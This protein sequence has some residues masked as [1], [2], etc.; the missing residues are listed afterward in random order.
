MN[1]WR[2]KDKLQNGINMA[3]WNAL[4]NLPIVSFG[5]SQKPLSIKGSK[6]TWSLKKE[7][8]LAYL[9]GSFWFS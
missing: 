4:Y 9:P 3:S 2:V 7:N 6:M 8:F 5:V 1:V